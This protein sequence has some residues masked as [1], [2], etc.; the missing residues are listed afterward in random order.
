MSA[1]DLTRAGRR[2]PRGSLIAAALASV[3][4]AAPGCSIKKLAV[5]KIGQALAEGTGTFASDED[6]EL[7]AAALPFS[8]K[9][10]ESLLAESPRHRGLLTATSSGFAQYSYAFVHQEADYLEELDFDRAI[11]GWERAKKLYLR[12]RDY[13]LRGLETSHEDFVTELYRD[14]RDAVSRSTD[15]DVALL[16]WTAASWAGAITLSK[17]D[18]D[19]VGD[20]PIVEA[21]ILRA[22]E[23]DEAYDHG[24]I[25]GFLIAFEMGR[26]GGAGDPVARAREHFDRAMELSDGQ[27]ASPLV[28]LAESVALAEQ[29]RNEFKGLLDRALAIDPETRPEWRLSNLISQQRA[30]WLLERTDRL[31]LD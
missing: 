20:L 7:I 5:N 9:L 28:T 13:G 12:A 1:P 30:R 10:M 17:D 14:P 19:L 6:P 3:L 8:L 4:V 15:A 31:I 27:L 26:P 22:L 11:A 2:V 25:H 23:L 21:L 29:D 18:P 16:F 24:A